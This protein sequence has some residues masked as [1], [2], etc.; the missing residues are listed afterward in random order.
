[1]LWH[2]TWL[3]TRWRFLIGL[4]LLMLLACGAVFEYPATA[5]L[6]P[7][8]QSIP[9]GSGVVGRAISD[10]IA[11]QRDYRGFI[12]WQWVRQNF[13]QLWTLFAVLLGSGGL[14][15]GG[16]S[17]ARF[18]L[19]LPVSRTRVIGVRAAA[20]FGELLILAFAPSLVIPLLSPAVGESYSVA[21]A[22]VHALCMFVGGACVFSF[23]LLMST[24]FTDVWRPAL[25]TC[26]VAI[27]LGVV[28][29][30]VR[31]SGPYGLFATMAG[32]SYFRA[33][34]MPWG[35][36]LASAAV[37]VALLY[38]ATMNFAQQDF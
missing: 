10:A 29:T 26:A 18:T 21:A 13:T 9:T 8:A 16:S 31:Q 2:K 32:E 37:S 38:G 19:S 6:L 24:T 23:A 34:V 15:A 17:G 12:W 25:V 27:G 11:T 5:R 20:C 4:A 1:M 7:L 22:L 30:A 14:L 35:G 33:A 36:L 28:E 3:E